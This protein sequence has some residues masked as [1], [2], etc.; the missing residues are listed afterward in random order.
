MIVLT[1]ILLAMVAGGCEKPPVPEQTESSSVAESRTTNGSLLDSLDVSGDIDTSA[2]TSPP[3]DPTTAV[4]LGLRT[5]KPATWLWQPPKRSMRKA[6]YLIPGRNGSEPAEL[7]V[8]HFPEAPGNTPEANIQR[9]T[10]QFR[11]VDGGPAKAQVERMT[12]ESMPVTLME[13]HGEYMGMG[14]AWHKADQRMVVAMVQAP[15]GSI[16]IK[17]LGP[18]DTVLVNRDDFMDFIRGLAPTR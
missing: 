15:A 9:W 2:S 11:S 17:M 1:T 16:F 6:N 12:V 4:F 18:D 5:S 10:S 3:D 13:I 14:G 8:T 7:I